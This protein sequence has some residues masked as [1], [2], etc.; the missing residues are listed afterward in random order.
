MNNCLYC[1]K[2]IK[3]ETSWKSILL[4]EQQMTICQE[5]HEKLKM[6][7]GNICPICGRPSKNEEACTDCIRWEKSD[8]KG[9]LQKN[10]SIYEYNEF[11]KG[12]LNQFKFRGDAVLAEMFRH[13]M[14]EAY[15]KY[16]SSNFTLLPIPL[17]EKRLHE[18][19]FNQSKLLAQILDLPMIE[20]LQKI[21]TKKQSK[22]SRKERIQSENMFT[23][24]KPNIVKNIDILIIDD[25]YTTGTTIR[26]AAKVLMEAGA[27][28]VQSLT[29]IRS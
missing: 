4:L 11:I 10:R 20:P 16:F 14:K 25:L 6:I 5:C 2:E 29:L 23:L 3:K 18:R 1:F 9:V 17:G 15:K 26:H 12:I 13:P 21:D 28:S 7:K 24:V 8:F 27:N 19:G 22:K